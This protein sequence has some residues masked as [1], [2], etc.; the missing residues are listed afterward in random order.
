VNRIR[1]IRVVKGER[2]EYRGSLSDFVQ[3]GDTVIVPER[4]F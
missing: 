4:F 3:P 1:I 2:K